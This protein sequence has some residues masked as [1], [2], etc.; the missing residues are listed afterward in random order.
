M[1][2]GRTNPKDVLRCLILQLAC[3]AQYFASVSRVL[4]LRLVEQQLPPNFEKLSRT[5]IET[6]KLFDRVFLVFD[7]L[8]E[9]EHREDV[10]TLFPTLATAKVSVFFTSH[11]QGANRQHWLITAAKIDLSARAED[12]KIYIQ[13]RIESSP[14]AKTLLEEGPNRDKLV[15]KL[16]ECANGM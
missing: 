11:P 10:L 8:D 7:G 9:Y 5:L 15:T 1:E 4:N 14:C 2:P 3:Q 6:S 12:I 16:T 13:Q